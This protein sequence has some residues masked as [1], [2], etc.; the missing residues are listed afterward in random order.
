MNY[1]LYVVSIPH[2]QCKT[3][4]F[5][6][7]F[8][9][10]TPHPLQNQLFSIMNFIRL[11]FPYNVSAYHTTI[12][13]ARNL[14]STSFRLTLLIFLSIIASSTHIYMVCIPPQSPYTSLISE[15]LDE[16]HI[17]KIFP[18]Y[19]SESFDTVFFQIPE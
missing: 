9:H 5:I 10:H 17:H 14:Q 19:R 16:S 4:A 1:T 15:F 11:H 6:S 2:R 18:D 13:R 7:F 12:E 3:T 8:L